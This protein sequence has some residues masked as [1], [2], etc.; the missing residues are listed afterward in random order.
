MFL[1]LLRLFIWP[2]Y[3]FVV[4][5]HSPEKSGTTYLPQVSIRETSLWPHVTK[6]LVKK[7]LLIVLR[8][9]SSLSPWLTA[10]T[11]LSHKPGD[12]LNSKLTKLKEWIATPTST[13]WISPEIRPAPW[14]K[15]GILSSRLLFNAKPPMVTVSD[16]SPSPSPR[17]PESKSKLPAMP[18]TPIKDSSER[19]WW[20]LCK[21]PFKGQLSRSSLRSCKCDY[22]LPCFL[23]LIICFI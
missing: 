8:E 15:N 14:L 23:I 3:H 4:F 19:R 13:V 7:W 21:L 10:T 5:T 9:E 6:T 12:N 16:F 2:F 1:P 11:K 20:R 18:R 17:R 22:F